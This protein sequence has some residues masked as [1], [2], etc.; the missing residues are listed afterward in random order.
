MKPLTD[1]YLQIAAGQGT[2]KIAVNIQQARENGIM[3]YFLQYS[4]GQKKFELSD[5]KEL[6]ELDTAVLDE[7][8]K[9]YP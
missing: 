5:Y 2:D 8:K 7:L 4:L 9:M 6:V 3:N 1:Q